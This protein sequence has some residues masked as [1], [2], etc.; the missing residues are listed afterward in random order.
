MALD[1]ELEEAVRSVVAEAKQPSAV[2][3]RIIAWL[4]ELS[5]TDLGPEDKSR[6]LDSVRSALNISGGASED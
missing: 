4:K 1:K 5:D 2:A 6:H 3:Q